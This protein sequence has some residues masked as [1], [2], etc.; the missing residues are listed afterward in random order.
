MSKI[1]KDLYDTIF[2]LL[3]EQEA[4]P[5]SVMTPEQKTESKP[6]PKPAPKPE[7]ANKKNKLKNLLSD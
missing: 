2:K 7:P 5:A 3:N 4:E 1:S 6:A